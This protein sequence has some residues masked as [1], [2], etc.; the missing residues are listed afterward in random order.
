MFYV[1]G[2]RPTQDTGHRP[3]TLPNSTP[4][5]LLYS[6]STAPETYQP[7]PSSLLH[8]EGQLLPW[9]VAHLASIPQGHGTFLNNT[10]PLCQPS[11]T[12]L[13]ACKPPCCSPQLRCPACHYNTAC[14]PATTKTPHRAPEARPHLAR[15]PSSALGSSDASRLAGEPPLFSAKTN[16]RTVPGSA[17]HPCVRERCAHHRPPPS[18]AC[19]LGPMHISSSDPS[20]LWDLDAAAIWHLYTVPTLNISRS[21]PSPHRWPDARL[22]ATCSFYPAHPLLPPQKLYLAAKKTG[23]L[24]YRMMLALVLPSLFVATHV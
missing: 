8:R 1:P 4:T 22:A 15:A 16:G 9:H 24:P 5:Q 3:L 17:K 18:S 10:Y 12:S 6:L 23:H 19:P 21:A 13:P 11:K 7:T 2:P 14:S 20:S